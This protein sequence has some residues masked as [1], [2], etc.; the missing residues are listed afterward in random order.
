LGNRWAA[1]S[2]VA[3]ERQSVVPQWVHFKPILGNT[4]K[5]RA[6]IHMNEEFVM[7]VTNTSSI[8]ILLTGDNPDAAGDAPYF[9]S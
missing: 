1:W 9:A 3:E 8:G 7:M 2:S 5:V 6:Y 4:S